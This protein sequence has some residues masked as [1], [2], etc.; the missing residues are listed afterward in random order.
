MSNSF[1]P[2]VDTVALLAPTGRLRGNHG[3]RQDAGRPY[4]LVNFTLSM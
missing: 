4:C 2:D 1:Q 3:R